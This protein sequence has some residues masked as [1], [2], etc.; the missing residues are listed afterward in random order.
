MTS[1]PITFGDG[2]RLIDLAEVRRIT[3]SGRTFVYGSMAAG[4]FPKCTKIGPSSVR[5]IESEV[6]EWVRDGMTCPR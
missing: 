1:S 2:D 3:G 5:W 6:L 4:T